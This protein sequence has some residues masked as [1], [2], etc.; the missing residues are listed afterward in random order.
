[1]TKTMHDV[2]TTEGDRRL[3]SI[4]RQHSAFMEALPTGV[5]P[6]LRKLPDIRAV[7]FDVYGTL[8]ISGS[9]D[10]GT[11]DISSKPPAFTDALRS[12]RL[13]YDGK[14]ATGVAILADVIAAHHQRDR[15]R[16]IE[17][18]EVDIREVWKDVLRRLNLTE[19]EPVDVTA[20]ALQYEVRT[21]PTW[22]MPHA[23]DC[24]HQLRNAGLPMGIVSNA[25]CFT[26]LL[27]PAQLNESLTS[28]GF[29]EDWCFWSYEHRQ[30]KP[31]TFLYQ[32]ARHA[33]EVAGISAEE[34]LY[35]GNDMLK[36]I[37]PASRVGFRTALFAGDVRS[38][39]PRTEDPRIADVTPDIVLTTWDQ[40]QECINQS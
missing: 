6:Q 2:A 39:R 13:D 28:L 12:V 35:I 4:I 32:L 20:L 10:V 40:L 8:F 24:L 33:T 38:Y 34:V 29:R 16:G 7:I 15:N 31:G 17:F 18:P 3:E 21:N 26:R 5:R 27:F 1:M 30:A 22:P 11:T 9:G 14:A 23:A 37:W 25:Q 36:D 19:S